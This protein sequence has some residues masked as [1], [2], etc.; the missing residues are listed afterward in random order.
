MVST[1]LLS[2]CGS[3]TTTVQDATQ[4]YQALGNSLFSSHV[5]ELLDSNPYV[6]TGIVRESFGLYSASDTDTVSSHIQLAAIIDTFNNNIQSSLEFSGAIED[7]KNSDMLGG[8][9][10]VYYIKSGDKQYVNWKS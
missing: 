5:F 10:L 2:G 1:L 8:S 7:K 3:S 4:A 9:G 6:H